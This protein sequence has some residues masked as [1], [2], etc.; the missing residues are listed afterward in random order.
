[1][2]KMILLSMLLISILTSCQ[3][4]TSLSPIW[5]QSV[6]FYTLPDELS[7][8]YPIEHYIELEMWNR[9]DAIDLNSEYLC[10]DTTIRS[11]L[12]IRRFIAFVNTLEIETAPYNLDLRSF[13]KVKYWFG[14]E[15]IICFGAENGIVFDG[16]LMKDNEAFLY[17]I[18]SEVYA[19][20]GDSY[21]RRE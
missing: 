6:H 19:P 12:F 17:F 4:A 9:A 8:R 11:R 16:H 15:S 10:R 18:H 5:V 14:K 20:H 3:H 1:M 2:K 21:W 7:E 13:A